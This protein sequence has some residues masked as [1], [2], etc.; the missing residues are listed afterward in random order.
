[1]QKRVQAELDSVVGS[2]LPTLKDLPLLPYTEAA[3]AE[4]QRIRSVV[5]VGIPHGALAVSTE[6]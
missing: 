4:T 6:Q 5:P 2:R 3:L 1:M